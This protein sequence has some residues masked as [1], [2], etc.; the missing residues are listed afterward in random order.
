MMR[1][2]LIGI[3]LAVLFVAGLWTAAHYIH[4]PAAG[5]ARAEV[6]AGFTGLRQF[7]DWQLAC[8]KPQPAASPK[9]GI[10]LELGPTV[11]APAPAQSALT[12]GRCRAS[13]VLVKKNDP[14]QPVLFL[15]FRYTSDGSKLAMIVRLPAPA[16]K[17]DTLMVR[18]TQKAGLKIPVRQCG[19]KYCFFGL[20][21]PDAQNLLL[22]VRRGVAIFPVAK[23][24]K[25]LEMLIPFQG[26]PEAL[27]AMR[28][29][30]G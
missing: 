17:T 10:P 13:L 19:Q 27:G 30:E 24:A 15:S 20:L 5:V 11:P 1:D 26:L 4:G 2:T 25:P 28:K 22:S 18:L 14:K 7:G 12:L 8:A 3:A 9:E 6:K 16:E 29:A 21:E 23:G